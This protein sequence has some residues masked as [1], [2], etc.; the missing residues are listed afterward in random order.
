MLEF[1]NYN[2][3]FKIYYLIY[4]KYVSLHSVYWIHFICTL[5]KTRTKESGISYMYVNRDF[6]GIDHS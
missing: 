6:I 1:Y 3:D 5:N 2:K 4:L